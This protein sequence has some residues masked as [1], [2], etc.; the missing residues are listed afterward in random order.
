MGSNGAARKRHGIPGER[1]RYFSPQPVRCGNAPVC[2][3][4]E[5]VSTG[6]VF[7]MQ[8]EVLL[9]FRLIATTA[10][11][12]LLGAGF[13][14]ALNY[15]RLFGVDPEMPSENSSSRAYS[16]V[17]I[18]TVWAHALVATAAFALFLH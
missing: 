12:G 10:F 17:Q 16:Q 18:F 2:I 1:K 9:I 6:T 15:R 3:W 14:M 8:N 11:F 4:R 13:W 7:R 5:G